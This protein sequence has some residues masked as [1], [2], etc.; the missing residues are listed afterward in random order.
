MNLKT[1]KLALVMS[2]AL[3]TAVSFA[4]GGGRGGMMRFGGGNSALMLAQDADVQAKINMTTDQK[5]K[6]QQLQDAMNQKRMDLFQEARDSGNM[7]GLR[8][9]M[10]KLQES[11]D[12]Q[13]AAIL[14]AKQMKRIGE[15]QIQLDGNR[16]ITREAVQKDLG[17][18]DEQKKMVTDITQKFQQELQTYFEEMRNGGGGFDRDAMQAEMKKRTEKLDAELGK[19]LTA[20]QTKKLK[21]LGGKEFKKKTGAGG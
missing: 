7:D 8:E 15:I 12:K 5:S 19:V 4:Q 2:M 16:S 14:D 6:V 1:M 18:S 3:M 9:S 21:E 10:T 11:A 13:L 17:L 20:A